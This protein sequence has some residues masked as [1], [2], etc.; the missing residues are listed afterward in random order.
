M[1]YL[2][3]RIVYG[4]KIASESLCQQLRNVVIHSAYALY[5]CALVAPVVNGE[6]HRW[7]HQENRVSD[8]RKLR[9]QI[10]LISRV[11]YYYEYACA[12][13]DSFHLRRSDRRGYEIC[14]LVHIMCA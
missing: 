12:Y 3:P 8:A 9:P 13:V 1:C 6:S 2:F 7:L 4:C 14:V 11:K 5:I 10:D